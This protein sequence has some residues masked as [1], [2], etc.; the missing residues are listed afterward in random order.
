MKKYRINFDFKKIKKNKSSVFLIDEEKKINLLRVKKKFLK[1]ILNLKKELDDLINE[2]KDKYILKIKYIDIPSKTNRFDFGLKYDNIDDILQRGIFTTEENGKLFSYLFYELSIENLK[3]LSKKFDLILSE[4]YNEDYYKFLEK[5]VG[6]KPDRIKIKSFN[7]KININNF[8]G[9]K[10]VK[11]IWIEN[12][13]KKLKNEGILREENFDETLMHAYLNKN[14]IERIDEIGNIIISKTENP[15]FTVNLLDEIDDFDEIMIS[16]EKVNSS[17]IGVID[18]GNSLSGDFSK[19]ILSNE[20]YKENLNSN[21]DFKHGSAVASLIIA[22]DIMNPGDGDNLGQFKIRHFEVLEKNDNTISVSFEHLK[23]FLQ[24]IIPKYKDEI[25]VWNLSLGGLKTPYSRIISDLGKLLDELSFKNNVLFV[26]ASG[27]ER[28]EFKSKSLNQPGDSLNAIT[29]GSSV[30]K[31]KFFSYS[32]YSSY[33]PILHYE[34]PEISYFGGPKNKDGSNLVLYSP[35]YNKNNNQGTSYAAPKVS[36]IIAKFISEGYSPTEAKAKLIIST[37]RESKGRRASAFGIPNLEDNPKIELC[38]TMEI[39]G[40][41]P[42]Y[43]DIDLPKGTEKVKISST[44][45]VELNKKFGEEYSIHNFDISLTWY[46]K[47]LENPEKD[48]MTKKV[49]KT[50]DR[51]REYGSEKFLRYENGKYFNTHIWET[52]A[53]KINEAKEHLKNKILERE[54]KINELDLNLA[55]RIKKLDL[56]RTKSDQIASISFILNIYGKEIDL[57]E[58]ENKNNELIIASIENEISIEI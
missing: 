39:K 41:R 3:W 24:N 57:I 12:V 42:Y 8:D 56:F 14:E 4:D 50:K 54:I 49:V 19:F 2:K 46:K 20:N 33:G 25:K 1:E 38:Q 47:G 18:S 21:S 15:K 13:I 11:L 7:A 45:F 6:Y 28:E 5:I 32:S 48:F 10:L 16:D 37:E 30:F 23:S 55:I 36:R 34:K 22:N 58:F 35:T 44:N 53:S 17:V 51:Y 43:F 52:N 40:N 31:N 26:V 29:V 27:N 9:I